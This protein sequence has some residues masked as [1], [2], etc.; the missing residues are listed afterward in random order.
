MKRNKSLVKRNTALASPNI[1]LGTIAI[2]ALVGLV[3]Y[4]I[5]KNRQKSTSGNYVN[6]KTWEIEV[7]SDGIPT[8][9]TKHVN[10]KVG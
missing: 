3:I 2:I 8:K 1:S 6:T 7:N 10:A 4:L 5:W 9:I